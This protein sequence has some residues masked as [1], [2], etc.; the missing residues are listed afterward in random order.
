MDFS[1][2]KNVYFN[3]SSRCEHCAVFLLECMLT[4]CSSLPQI[5]HCNKHLTTFLWQKFCPSLI[6]VLG[7]PRVD[8]NIVTRSGSVEEERGRGSGCLGTAPSFS[9]VHAKTV[10]S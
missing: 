5:V 1:C 9:S 7:T 4:L 3:S 10:Y 8:K 6:T 2:S